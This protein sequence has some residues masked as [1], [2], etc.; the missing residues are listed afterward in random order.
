MKSIPI[1]FGT[2]NIKSKVLPVIDT[3]SA[4]VKNFVSIV[5]RQGFWE[6]FSRT[7]GKRVKE[8]VA[9]ERKGRKEGNLYAD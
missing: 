5:D 7:R 6:R 4:F 1:I 8:E 2:M 9:A 3:S